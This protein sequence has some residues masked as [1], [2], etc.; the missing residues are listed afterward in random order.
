MTTHMNEP[1][2]PFPVEATSI[3]N[4]DAPSHSAAP[5]EFG[6]GNTLLER[7]YRTIGPLAGGLMLDYTDFVTI[8]ITGGPFG[9]VAGLIVGY[10]VGY[11]VSRMYGFSTTGRA[12][13]AMIAAVYCALPFTNLFPL[14]TII[15]AA[16]RFF[17]ESPARSDSSLHMPVP[18]DENQDLPPT[19]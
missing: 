2:P 14:A 4:D 18:V 8:G 15:S 10:A 17:H 9:I 12:V 6:M 7:I 11:W 19:Q 3:S 13:F 1:L 5:V 16:A